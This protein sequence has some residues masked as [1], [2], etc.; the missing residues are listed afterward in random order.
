MNQH[1]EKM[2]TT[3]EERFHAELSDWNGFAEFFHL[4][5]LKDNE[6]WIKAGQSCEEFFYIAEGLVR[7]YYVD[8]EG[9]EVNEGFYEEGM[10]LGPISS[11]V[12]G[13]PCPYYIQT[14]E[15]ATLLVANYPK[16]HDYALDK[17][18][19]LNFEITFMHSL[20]VSNAKRDA[21]RLICN[22]EQRY[23]WFCKEYNH[24]LERIPQYHIASFLGMTP[25]SLSRLKKNQNREGK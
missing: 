4:Q 5:Q 16:F 25:V 1:F 14:V 11:F 10:L 12:S 9:N 17:P 2:R 18:E 15:P 23:R 20:F 7:I 22:G 13:A 21:K 6:H 8:Q 24:L 3:L 19:I